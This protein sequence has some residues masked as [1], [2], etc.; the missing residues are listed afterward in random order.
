MPPTHREGDSA[1]PKE[2]MLLGVL[3]TSSDPRIVDLKH[4]GLPTYQHRYRGDIFGCRLVL[5][6][7]KEGLHG[8]CIFV[9]PG[10]IL[11]RAGFVRGQERT[12]VL[13]GRGQVLVVVTC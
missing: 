13:A 11:L 3:T 6:L 9:P 5:P 1:T 12:A 10:C 4:T 7:F 2:V 8:L